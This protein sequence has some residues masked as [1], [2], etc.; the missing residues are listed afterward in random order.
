MG[1]TFLCHMVKRPI[2]CEKNPLIAA[3]V[4][5]CNNILVSRLYLNSL[6]H[7]QVILQYNCLFPEC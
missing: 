2:S 6:Q 7:K 1:I 3:P 4:S 5:A